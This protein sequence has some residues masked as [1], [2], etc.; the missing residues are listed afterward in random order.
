KWDEAEP[1]YRRAMERF[2][3]LSPKEAR[4]LASAQTSLGLLIVGRETERRRLESGSSAEEGEDSKW[5]ELLEEAEDLL[6]EAVDFFEECV[7]AATEEYRRALTAL[8]ALYRLQAE[9]WDVR[10]EM[11]EVEA[12]LEELERAGASAE[13]PLLRPDRVLPGPIPNGPRG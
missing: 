10:Q 7:P 1:P 6:V 2:S 11:V 12:E 13:S 3:R 5:E 9:V 4:R 8:R